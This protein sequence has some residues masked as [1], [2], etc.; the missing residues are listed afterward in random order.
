MEGNTP[1]CSLGCFLRCSSV[2]KAWSRLQHRAV[3]TL[4]R[5]PRTSSP[6]IHALVLYLSLFFTSLWSLLSVSSLQYTHSPTPP[7]ST[8]HSSSHFSTLQ[9][10]HFVSFKHSHTGVVLCRVHVP[11]PVHIL[12]VWLSYAWVFSSPS[13]CSCGVHPSG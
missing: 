11:L 2:V 1:C 3:S 10:C 9:R 7:L 8:L 13:G 12:T 4:R 5:R 6:V